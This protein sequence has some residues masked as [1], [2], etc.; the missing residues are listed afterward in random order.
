MHGQD[1]AGRAGQHAHDQDHDDPAVRNLRPFMI[2]PSY[3]RSRIDPLSSLSTAWA[4]MMSA[5]RRALDCAL[6]FY[7]F[8]SSCSPHSG[9]ISVGDRDRACLGDRRSPRVQGTGARPG[10]ED[11]LAWAWA[12]GT[13]AHSGGAE[14]GQQSGASGN[15]PTFP[16]E[17]APRMGRSPQRPQRSVVPELLPIPQAG[18]APRR[19]DSACVRCCVAVRKYCVKMCCR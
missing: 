19:S 1:A 9:W 10:L 18:R 4:G 12:A 13:G 7:S 3:S 2:V 14:I 8:S 16:P 6:V 17:A 5:P 15:G 11:R